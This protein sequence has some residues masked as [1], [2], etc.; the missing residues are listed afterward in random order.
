VPSALVMAIT[1]PGGGDERA[2]GVV[3]VDRY[4]QV[5]RVGG[6]GIQ[7]IREEGGGGEEEGEEE[8]GCQAGGEELRVQGH[9]CFT[10]R[11]RYINRSPVGT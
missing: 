4:G 1:P 5:D 9:E 7:V 3:A 6:F 11:E 8:P 10:L 2:D